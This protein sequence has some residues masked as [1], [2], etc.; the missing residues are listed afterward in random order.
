MLVG[1]IPLL[2]LVCTIMPIPVAF[3]VY[4]IHTENGKEVDA[5]MRWHPDRFHN[6]IDIRRILWNDPVQRT[7]YKCTRGTNAHNAQTQIA[8][9]DDCRFYEACVHVFK[10]VED[11]VTENLICS[12]VVPV[13]CSAGDHR[14]H[15]VVEAVVNRVLN[16]ATVGDI[17]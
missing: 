10:A 14:S 6:P 9:L 4:G 11:D 8:M 2:T 5:H 3:V 1:H 15:S 12:K 7:R 16:S 17:R 13:Y